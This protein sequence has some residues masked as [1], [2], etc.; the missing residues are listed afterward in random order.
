MPGPI[1]ECRDQDDRFFTGVVC[2]DGSGSLTLGD[3][4]DELVERRAA[5]QIA[6]AELGRYSAVIMLG[7]TSDAVRSTG[8]IEL[9]AK[10]LIELLARGGPERVLTHSPLDRHDTHVAVAMATVSAAAQS[11]PDDRPESLLGCEGWGGLDWLDPDE[12]V[13]LP[14]GDPEGA[15]EL[16]QCFASQLEHKRYDLAA[17]GRR[18]SNAT[19]AE[20]LLADASPEVSLALD[21][22]GAMASDGDVLR[23]ANEVTDRFRKRL[24]DRL[25]SPPA[26][27][28]G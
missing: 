10:V 15:L 24:L 21:M 6:A 1:L 11:G 9:L 13:A 7:F 5:E 16:A 3:N 19:F 8:G 26:D 20:P 4:G 18:R 25:K 14:V 17:Q 2:T 28:R 22:T 27:W 23:Q 12:T